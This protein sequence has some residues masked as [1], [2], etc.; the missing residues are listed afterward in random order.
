MI[1]DFHCERAHAKDPLLSESNDES[2]SLRIATNHIKV[3]MPSEQLKGF[4]GFRSF[5]RW[6]YLAWKKQLQRILPG[7]LP[8]YQ[9][10][11]P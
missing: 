5:F 7:S 3:A 11:L 8:S 10:W 9:L 4:G 2:S 6:Y 1:F